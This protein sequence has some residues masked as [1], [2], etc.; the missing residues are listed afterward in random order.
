VTA[1][2]TSAQAGE[3]LLSGQSWTDLCEVTRLAGQIVEQLGDDVSDLERAEWYRFITRLSRIACERFVEGLDPN[4]PSLR[5]ISWRASLNFTSPLQDHLFGEFIDGFTDYV[6]TG[7]RGTVPYFIVSVWTTP[8]P[9]DPA[10]QDWAGRGVAGLAEFNPA[11][12][13]TTSF[14]TS[15][16]LT[17]DEAGNFSVVVS[18]T[19]PENGGAWLQP[20]ADCVGMFVRWVYDERDGAVPPTM[21]IERLD[22]AARAPIRPENLALA[23]SRAGQMVLGFADWMRRWWEDLSQRLNTVQFSEQ[24]YLTHGGVADRYHGFGAWE[25]SEDEALVIR[26]TPT[27]CDFWTFQLCNIWEENLDNYAD[28][29]GYMYKAGATYEPDGSVVAVLADTDP[30]LGGNFLDPCGPRT[31]G[32]WSFR[33]VH[34]QGPP[35][36]LLVHRVKLADLQRDGLACTDA[37]PAIISG[38]GSGA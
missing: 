35:P 10:D 5:D 28:G 24:V 29:E 13:H 1:A 4:R 19:Q 22:R 33:L 18:Q 14:V 20:T 37:T 25:R 12:F 27:P 17:F 8:E 16:E 6:L 34:P 3:R 15:D 31:R 2:K 30:G 7:N 9:P 23:F 36:E 38:G 32:T 11:I 21:Q 26:F